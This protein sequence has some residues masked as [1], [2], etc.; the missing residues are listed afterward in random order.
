MSSLKE[1]SNAGTSTGSLWGGG[2]GGGGCKCWTKH[3]DTVGGVN[4]EGGGD[5]SE[6]TKEE[7]TGM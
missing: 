1:I 6:D 4:A 5:A 7:G 2:G 3:R